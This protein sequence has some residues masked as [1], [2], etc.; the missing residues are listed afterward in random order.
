MK[1]RAKASGIKDG[2]LYLNG[3]PDFCFSADYPYYRDQ[4][5]DWAVQLSAIKKM[6]INYVSF[7]IPWRHHLPELLKGAGS[8]QV[9]VISG[10]AYL[11]HS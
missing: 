5:A 9:F 4:R 3:R 10:S 7:Y 11:Q 8:V 6:G 2:A 1:L